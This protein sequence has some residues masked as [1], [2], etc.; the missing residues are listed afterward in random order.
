MV[1]GMGG[2]VSGGW[3]VRH[4][5]LEVSKKHP[6]REIGSDQH[7]IQ[8]FAPAPQNQVSSKIENSG[9]SSK[10]RKSSNWLFRHQYPTNRPRVASV[11]LLLL[12]RAR[13]GGGPVR[14]GR[15]VAEIDRLGR[16]GTCRGGE[17]GALNPHGCCF[18]RPRCCR[19]RQPASSGGLS[20]Y[21]LYFCCL[22][23][24]LLPG[25]RRR[26]CRRTP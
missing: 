9:C 13:F 3:R 2:Q 26:R 10:N 15:L 16:F 7:S 23:A 4:R 19:R 5:D 20:S 11:G 18:P 8:Y 25:G 12:T 17:D 14:F 6:K 24:R 1:R 22:W 21:W